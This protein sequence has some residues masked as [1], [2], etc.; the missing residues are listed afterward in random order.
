MSNIWEVLLQSLTVTVVALVLLIVKT[1]L[2]D[3]L[4]PRWQYGVWSVL[5][6]R[7]VWPASMDSRLLFNFPLWF[8]LWKSKAEAG[9]NSAYAAEYELLTPRHG[10]PEIFAAP[11][12]LTDWLF[13]IY[14]VGVAAFLAWHLIGYIRLRLLLRHGNRPSAEI[15]AS[16]A[17]AAEKYALPYCRAVIVPGLPSAFVCGVF[18]P[19]LAL[20][21]GAVPDEKV[22]LHELL[23]LRSRD[24]LQNILWCIFR[25]VHWFNF[26]LWLV[27]DRIG[28]DLESLCDQRVLE[29]LEGEERREYGVILLSMASK[30]YA[31]APGTSSISNGGDN[32]SSR[33]EA[34]ARFKKYPAG[35]ALVSVCIAFF[36]CFTMISGSAVAYSSSEYYPHEDRELPRAMAIARMKRCSTPDAAIDTYAKALLQQNGVYLAVC[37]PIEEH[38]ALAEQMLGYDELPGTGVCRMDINF[39]QFQHHQNTFSVFELEEQ[40]D[41]AWT[42]TLSFPLNAYTDEDGN[43]ALTAEGN[44]ARGSLLIPVTTLWDGSGWVV[45]ESG[46]REFIPHTS[47]SGLL[48]NEVYPFSRV[49]SGTGDYGTVT[50]TTAYRYVDD[51]DGP[52]FWWGTADYSIDT[53]MVYDNI[54]MAL[55]VEYDAR[56]R[57]LDVAPVYGRVAAVEVVALLSPDDEPEFLTEPWMDYTSYSRWQDGHMYYRDICYQDWNGLVQTGTS[58]TVSCAEFSDCTLQNVWGFA[59]RIFWDNELVEEFIIEEVQP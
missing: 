8:E 36:L 17:Y 33:I 12:S 46:E 49:F 56:S 41:G 58:G 31:R 47:Y 9:R 10:L 34:I 5:A 52:F 44:A 14:L 30:D 45:R 59:V 27:F 53:D 32:I 25:C 54:T 16:I 28:N 42:A 6:L 3:K 24:V 1:A 50:V 23:H 29:R 11:Q 55:D 48:Y 18:R 26:V 21:E 7:L 40:P 43:V 22:L 4:S 19:V 20:P 13:V 39:E 38:F 37:T 2:A 51:Q 15:S 35:M 57:N